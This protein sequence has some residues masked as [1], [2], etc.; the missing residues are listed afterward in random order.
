MPSINDIVQIAEAMEKSP[1]AVVPERC[2][3]VRNRNAKCRKCIDVCQV[4]AIEI[5]ANE[6]N[7]NATACMACGACTSVCPTE[8][9]VPVSPSDADLAKAAAEAAAANEGVAVF[10]CARMAAKR[11]ADPSLF[12]EVPCLARLDES[13]VLSLVSH[14]ALRVIFVDG[15]CSSCKY[16]ACDAVIGATIQETDVLLE[17]HGSPVRVERMSAFPEEMLVENAQDKYG[18]TRRGFFSEAAGAAKD[19]VATAART[20]I[21]RELGYSADKA[22]VGERL[23]VSETGEMPQFAMPRH[24]VAINALDALGGPVVD[25]I[26]SRL[27]GTVDID[28]DRCNACN[29]CAV[30]CPSGAL[31]RDPAEKALAALKYL[32]FS[33]ADCVQCGL[34]ADVCW[35]KALTVS[36]DVSADELY[37]FEPRTFYMKGVRRRKKPFG[38]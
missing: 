31:R 8:A 36:S 23:R 11:A 3:S 24:E 7:L 30:F 37:D 9:L 17:T 18:A 2:V 20:T 28:I 34:C 19:T 13:L 14:G 15:D 29:M 5:F 25:S 38:A 21:E 26:D 35:K 16:G 12:A 4:G 32:E 27:F 1:V 6:F 10:A 22:S 33:A